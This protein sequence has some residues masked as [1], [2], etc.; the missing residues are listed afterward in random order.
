MKECVHC[1]KESSFN[2]QKL[3]SIQQP[4]ICWIGGCVVPYQFKNW[5]QCFCDIS[6]ALLVECQPVI[7]ELNNIQQPYC[8]QLHLNDNWS[9]VNSNNRFPW[10]PKP[11]KMTV[12]HPKIGVVVSYN[13]QKWRFWVPMV[14]MIESVPNDPPP[15]ALVQL[16]R[17][18]SMREV[19]NEF[20]VPTAQWSKELSR[21]CLAFKTKTRC[22]LTIPK[23]I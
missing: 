16:E 8:V 19:G 6:T 20:L 3:N 7:E 15:Q 13:P 18:V 5:H 1:L 11:W 17:Y 4:Y 23:G 21:R 10:T 2:D 22:K 9:H 14:D 12:L